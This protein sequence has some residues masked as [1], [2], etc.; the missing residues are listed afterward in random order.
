MRIWTSLAVVCVA[1]GTVGC[2]TDDPVTRSGSDVQVVLESESL[3][4]TWY[5]W[6]WTEDTN[7]NR[8]LEMEPDLD[9][10]G[11]LDVSE[12]LN[13][14]GVLDPGEDVDGDGRLDRNE[15][16][17]LN[18]TR[19]LED[20]VLGNGV[21]DTGI[22]CEEGPSPVLGPAPVPIAGDILLYRAGNPEP[23]VIASA[24][25][26]GGFNGLTPY[27]DRVLGTPSEVD[28]EVVY[29]LEEPF[30]QTIPVS[31]GR[32]LSAASRKIM[33]AETAI[34]P[35][36]P[37]GS[38]Y[39]GRCV[40]GFEYGT[41]NL[42]KPLPVTFSGQPG[43]IVVVRVQMAENFLSGF[44]HRP[45]PNDPTPAD[46]PDLSG[47]AFSNGQELSPKGVT[48]TPEPGGSISFSV[49]VR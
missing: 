26:S 25:S 40:V 16:T 14:N 17:N 32:L 10:D 21:I 24:S 27:D 38:D 13:N 29:D 11:N 20:I 30:T 8:I 19:E 34:S 39:T 1:L 23:E 43:D 28:R 4:D 31:N 42:G 33:N 15:D 49:T 48:V 2:E 44:L 22:W 18:G 36:A 45:D 12:D 47:A 37:G 6:D 46:P 7:G 35:P 9:G 5:V 3:N 41:P